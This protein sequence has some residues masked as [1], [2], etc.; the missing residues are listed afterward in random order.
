MK[1]HCQGA[2]AFLVVL[3]SFVF[4]PSVFAENENSSGEVINK[5]DVQI[6]VNKDA[7]VN[8]E[9]R[10]VYDFKTNERHGIYR[11][12]ERVFYKD[13]LKYKILIDNIEV[14]DERGDRY[15]TEL[16]NFSDELN[17]RIGDGNILITGEHTYIIKYR[18]RSAIGYFDNIDEIYWNAVGN[19]WNVPIL[20]SSVLIKLPENVPKESLRFSCYVGEYGSNKLC[21][22]DSEIEYSPDS[23]KVDYKKTLNA[24]EGLTVALGFPKGIVVEPSWLAKNTML[25]I[26]LGVDGLLILI[27][28]YLIG[29]FW[30]VWSKEGRDPKGRGVIVPEYDVPDNLT[31]LEVSA[32]LNQR[33]KSEDISAEIINLAVSGYLIIKS[34]EKKILN[35]NAGSEYSLI[36]TKKEVIDLYEYD[37]IILQEIFGGYDTYDKEVKLSDLDEKFYKIINDIKKAV[38]D[39]VFKKGF[40]TKNVDDSIKSGYFA[41]IIVVIVIAFFSMFGLVSLIESGL[42]HAWTAAVA[43]LLIFIPIVILVIA[44]YV[45]PKKTDHGIEMKEKIEG[46][47]LYLKI[48]EKN[49][50]EFHNAPEKKPEVFEKLLPFAMILGVAEIWA[51]EFV[52]IYQTPPSW[53]QGPMN[54]S[55]ANFASAFVNDMNS[56]TSTS[57]SSLTSHPSSSGS[58]FSGSGG[59]GFSGGGGGGGGGGSW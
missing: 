56:F 34:K 4:A 58:G 36:R 53:Y 30:Y 59:G 16:T 22:S 9:E 7:S 52:G 5:F 55:D 51:K 24:G 6:V 14:V 44:Y 32:I 46:L 33:I 50:I 2:I 38:N 39:S 40:Y 26:S 37:K 18:V 21:V 47:T 28:A 15:T 10:I 11:N 27:L 49:R 45:M 8:I 42:L 3:F 31:P 1:K 54:L 57:N 13:K 19:K 29:R 48:A 25:L 35:F 12:I 20:N 43:T 41:L 23:L 17:I